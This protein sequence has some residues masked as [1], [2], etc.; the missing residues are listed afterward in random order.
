VLALKSTMV[1]RPVSFS[2]HSWSSTAAATDPM[3][4]IRED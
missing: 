2:C 3:V 4:A 1:R